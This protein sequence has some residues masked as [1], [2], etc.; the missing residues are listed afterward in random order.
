MNMSLRSQIIVITPRSSPRLDL[1]SYQSH[2]IMRPQAACATRHAADSECNL[3]ARQF[4]DLQQPVFLG[5]AVQLSPVEPVD[6]LL[7]L[8]F[9]MTV[10]SQA[11]TSG[12][13]LPYAN[14]RH[15]AS[16]SL[17]RADLL[18]EVLSAV[19]LFSNKLLTAALRRARPLSHHQE[20]QV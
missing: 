5:F 20:R 13:G 10:S 14:L 18:A 16:H 3:A 2:V 1:R 4:P 19:A 15:T 7:P 6:F 9:G 17:R 12:M 8:R 11:V